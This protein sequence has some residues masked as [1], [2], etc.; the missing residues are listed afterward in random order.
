MTGLHHSNRTENGRSTEGAYFDKVA[1]IPVDVH[2][3]VSTTQAAQHDTQHIGEVVHVP[4]LMQRE[5]P[6]IPDDDDPCF[7]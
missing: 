5:I 2:R 1:D 3:Q 6:T 7:D 4:A